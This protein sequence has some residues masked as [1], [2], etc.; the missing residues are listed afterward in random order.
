ML[1]WRRWDDLLEVMEEKDISLEI[2]NILKNLQSNILQKEDL[3]ELEEYEESFPNIDISIDE[4]NTIDEILQLALP[5][6][7]S[8]L[9]FKK[10][11]SYNV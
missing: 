11:M 9:L 2:Q 1:L 8:L 5:L 6:K 3:S 10:H 4:E 7:N